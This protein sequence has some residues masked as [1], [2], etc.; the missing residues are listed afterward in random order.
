[1]PSDAGE[2]FGSG[3]S[4]AAPRWCAAIAAVMGVLPANLRSAPY[5]DTI[6]LFTANTTSEGFTVPNLKAAIQMAGQSH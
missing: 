3:T 4:F 2:Y 6:V 5:A 1:L